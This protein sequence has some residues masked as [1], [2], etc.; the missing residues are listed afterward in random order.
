M[1][2]FHPYAFVGRTRIVFAA[3]FGWPPGFI[4][5]AFIHLGVVLAETVLKEVNKK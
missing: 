5:Q 3:P 2:V 4:K 1:P